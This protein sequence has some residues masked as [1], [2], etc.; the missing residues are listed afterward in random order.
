MNLG[1]LPKLSG[2]AYYNY[3]FYYIKNGCQNDPGGRAA[4][5]GLPGHPLIYNLP[6]YPPAREYRPAR[7]GGWVYED[8]CE[9]L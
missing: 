6:P 8:G 4:Y 5:A 9:P 2:W 3:K 7:V 1:F